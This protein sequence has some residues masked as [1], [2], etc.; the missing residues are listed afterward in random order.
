MLQKKD[1]TTAIKALKRL[2]KAVG[3]APGSVTY[4]SIVRLGNSM[5]A[6]NTSLDLFE[7]K[8]SLIPWDPTAKPLDLASWYHCHVR[9]DKFSADAS[10]T[11]LLCTR[12]MFMVSWD[13]WHANWNVCINGLKGAHAWGRRGNKH[14]T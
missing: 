5:R 12:G 2:K 13:E 4:A 1:K 14:K 7:A 11:N 8:R 10:A 6:V 9:Q 3:P